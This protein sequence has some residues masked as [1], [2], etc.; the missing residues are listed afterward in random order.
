MAQ[1]TSASTTS[2]K[3]LAAYFNSS[4]AADNTNSY[5]MAHAQQKAS[6]KSIVE[7]LIVQCNMPI[8]IVENKHFCKFLTTVDSRYVP[9][10][11]SGAAAYIERMVDATRKSVQDQLEL[12]KSVCITVDIWSDRRMRAFISVTAHYTAC[13]DSSL[14][15]LKSSLLCCDRVIG[16]HTGE[17]IAAQLESILDGYEIKQKVDFVIT[18]NAA[19]MRKAMTLAFSVDNNATTDADVDDD[20]GMQLDVDSPDIWNH[21]EANDDEEVQAAMIS[22]C[23]KERLSCFDHTLNL[24]VGDGLKETKCISTALAK[25]CKISSL[26]HTSSSFKDA[27]ESAFGKDRSLPAVVV[28]RWNST[29]RQIKAVMALDNKLL[30]DTLEKQG[31]KNLTFSARET[32]Q[33]NELIEI[34]DPFMEATTITEG[35]KVVTISFAFPS[36]LSLLNHLDELLNQHRLK[37]CMPVARSLLKS[38]NHRFS[39]MLRRVYIEQSD[40]D[41][42]CLPFSSD[43]YIISSFFDPRFQLRWINQELQKMANTDLISLREEIIGWFAPDMAYSIH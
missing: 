37:Y 8:S 24:C 1:N 30:T 43:I 7:D 19:N 13:N 27:F 34:L 36:V 14:P 25:S 22:H 4:T 38:V 10:S 11:R 18:D 16:S 20:D 29:L 9:I 28:T 31:H 23:R 41:L 40:V 12:V 17:K 39:G 42:H 21:L 3:P 35:D 5:G 2:Q 15:A 33:L 26:L 32:C 6:T